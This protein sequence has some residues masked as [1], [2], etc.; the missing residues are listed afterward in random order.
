MRIRIEH[1]LKDGK[2]EYKNELKSFNRKF[3]RL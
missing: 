2:F 3:F 1:D